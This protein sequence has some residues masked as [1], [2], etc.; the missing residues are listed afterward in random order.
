MLLSL[1]VVMLGAY[2]RL[3]DAG[4]GCPDWPGCYGHIVLA[5]TTTEL[6]QAQNIYP[7]IPIDVHKA[8]IEMTHRYVAGILALL[9]I[10][11]SWKI[12]T[13]SALPKL[14]SWTL[15]LLLGLQAALGMWTVTL[16]LLPVVVMG[17]L[18]GGILLLTC[19]SYV[20][21]QL[22]SMERV[23]LPVWHR[24]LQLGCLIVLIQI[25]LGGWVSANYSGL[26]CIGF[27]LCN[28]LWIYN[29]DFTQGFNL[30]SAVGLNYQGGL[31]ESSG[32]I[33]IHWVHRL[34][35]VITVIYVVIIASAIA[36]K[37]KNQSTS[38]IAVGIICLLILQFILGIINVVYLLPL[39]AALLHNGI[40]AVLL[41]AVTS[42]C[43]LTGLKR[44][45]K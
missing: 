14:L 27:P 42:L 26:A 33:A 5:S 20:C 36:I 39:W 11:I 22:S 43:Y 31:L 32:R 29:V 16:K 28:G 8:W 34:W 19:L 15:L 25:A 3:V 30:S 37:T 7:T 38:W 41:A 44:V 13:I 2:T 1:V 21:C 12:F 24:L 35:A 4:L 23:Y 40:A 10:F 9:V 6:S 45:A 18:L 17:H